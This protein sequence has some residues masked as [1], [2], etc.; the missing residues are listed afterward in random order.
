MGERYWGGGVREAIPNI[1]AGN[2]KQIKAV[3]HHAATRSITRSE[4]E[5]NAKLLLFALTG[6]QIRNATRP[7]T[8]KLSSEHFVYS[9]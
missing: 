4:A 8:T 5:V 1:S 6:E 7:I 2:A 9:S 3:N